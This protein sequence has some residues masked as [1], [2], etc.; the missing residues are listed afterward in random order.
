M[1]NL[2]ETLDS[3]RDSEENFLSNKRHPAKDDPT[4]PAG[5]TEEPVSASSN[6]EDVSAAPATA[7][8]P[9][10]AK[11]IPTERVFHGDTYIDN[12][13]WL[14]NKEDPEVLELLG[15]ENAYTD[16]LLAPLEP[17]RQNLYA[18]YK[19]RTVEADTTVPQRCGDWWYYERTWEGRQYPAVY[20]IPATGE[21]RP[22]PGGPYEQLV[23]DGNSLAAGEEFFRVSGFMPSPDGKLGAMGVDFQGGETFTLRVFEI[24]TGL[25]VDDSVTNIGYGLAWAAD[26]SGV[27]Y[28][29]TNAAWRSYQVWLHPLAAQTDILLFQEDD[30]RFEVSL[31]ASRNNKWV[32]VTS[33]SR[34]TTEVRLIPTASPADQ[35]THYV[36]LPRQDGLEYQVEPAG[37]QLLITH[38]LNNP[39]FEI[40]SAPMCTSNLAEWV[41]VFSPQAGERIDAV[42]AYRDF[43]VISMRSGGETELRVMH[44]ATRPPRVLLDAPAIALP[45]PQL[46]ESAPAPEAGATASAPESSAAASPASTTPNTAASQIAAASGAV[47]VTGETG[48]AAQTASETET[49]TE[50]AANTPATEWET[51]VVIPRVPGSTVATQPD[52]YWEASE[53]VYTEQSLLEPPTQRV[54]EPATRRQHTLKQRQVPG[55]DHTRYEQQNVWVTARDGVQVPMTI[56][57]R[58][59]LQPDGTNPGYIYGYGSYEVS[60]DPYFSVSWASFLDR[61]VVIAWTHLRG[62]GELGRAWYEDGKLDKKKNTF[63]DF[64]DCGNWL[65]E[66]G[67]VAPGRLAAEG[68]SAGGLLIGA[69]INE[70]PELFRTVVAGVPFVDA[71]TTILQPELPLTVGEWEEWGNPVEDPDVYAYMKSYS[72]VENVRQV[73]YPSVLA[74]TS[75]NDV[76]VFYVEAAKW[77]QV[78]REQTANGPDRPILLKIEMVAGHAG[79]SGRYGAWEQRAFEQA[80][81]LDQIDAGTLL[82]VAGAENSAPKAGE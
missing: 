19:A 1:V 62:G 29:R 10:V 63:H 74:T 24:E 49:E 51:P 80:W 75:L 81:L 54:F 14:R 32:T 36:V 20:R 42:E 30:E 11:K 78:L 82:P 34:T 64:V 57:Y 5:P 6:P 15:A 40:A 31:E 18:E 56:V 22:Q 50:S 37:N 67:W 39:D 61:G 59:G 52:A 25:V 72:P 33:E 26:S 77:V 17:L 38:N 44:R 66:S 60:L 47:P 55:Y 16:A 71:L 13:E 27:I 73:Q 53:V 76:R 28:T 41:T 8:H 21:E 9:P 69:A 70:A 48:E 4:L 65:L 3:S 23:W 79:K 45:T 35:S 46:A 12:Y 58:K 7:P 68:A 43:A 2:R